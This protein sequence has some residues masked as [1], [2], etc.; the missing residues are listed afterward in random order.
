[1]TLKVNIAEFAALVD[2][3]WLTVNQHPKADLFIANYT[4]KCMYEEHWTPETLAA[5]GLI[6]DADGTVHARPFE[7]FFSLRQWGDDIAVPDEPFEL[8]EKLDGSMGIAYWGPDGWAI[9]TRGSF[10]GEQA[11]RATKMLA[12]YIDV[13]DLIALP[14]DRTYLFEII[15]P[16]NRIVVN[17]AGRTALV[18]LA[19]LDN[20]S[21][22]D[23]PLDD[24]R[25]PHVRR[26]TAPER[27]GEQDILAL[28]PHEN[29]EGFVARFVPSCLRIKIKTADYYAMHRFVTETTPKHIWEFLRSGGDIETL[30]NGAP[31]QWAD[32]AR[33]AGDEFLYQHRRC[34]EQLDRAYEWLCREGITIDRASHPREYRKQFAEHVLRYSESLRPSLF[35]LYD[36]R[37]DDAYRAL[38][39]GL[40]PTPDDEEVA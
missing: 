1:M 36:G 37:A 29:F 39:D 8:T 24:D 30:L 40:K 16:E 9:A 31:S 26:Y 21:G 11:T 27:F 34:R 19:I 32:E 6:F 5:R 2:D 22:Q 15:Y 33:A 25:F 17:Y 23:L 13:R 7:K 18:L 38:W 10:E 20:E 28:V 14:H 4:P 3:G 12:D 35:L